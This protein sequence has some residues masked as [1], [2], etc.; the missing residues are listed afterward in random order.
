MRAHMHRRRRPWRRAA[1][2]LTALVAGGS[3][4]TAVTAATGAAG[5]PAACHDN[6]QITD[7]SGDGHHATTDVLAAWFS[8]AGSRLQ[9]VVQVRAGTW[10]AEHEDPEIPGSGFAV[11][12]TVAGQTRFVR[13]TAPGPDHPG[14]PVTYDH[15]TYTRAGGF[16]SAGATTGST[17]TAT[18]GTVTIDVPAATGAT[19]GVTLAN[20]FVLTYDGI[21]S[22]VPDWVDHA[23]GGTSPDD[24][25]RGADYVVGSCA[26]AT[27]TTGTGTTTP[28]GTIPGDAPPQPTS[29]VQ[30]TARSRVVGGGTITVS[31]RV[32]PAR[33]GV[34]VT[35]TR[36]A[37]R[38]ASTKA[39]TKAD[40]TFSVKVP[41]QETTELRAVAEGIG[42]QTRTVTAFTTVKVK[43]VR[44]RDGSAV[45]TGTV[46]PKLP[47]RVLWLRGDAISPSARTTTRAGAFRL[48]LPHPRHGRYQAVVIPTGDRAE[49]ATSNTGVIR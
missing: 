49:R 10:V 41:I 39:T 11:L 37:H 19:A 48:R 16:A 13:A 14:S 28:T 2:G 15:G 26:S 30:L 18:S 44:K 25:S 23:P 17:V 38:T 9:A 24:P 21:T 33:A 12:F 31:G 32:L 43:V 8:E 40:G 5:P 4:G 6:P 36:R 29:A 47:G 35:L 45:V 27:P 7:A 20:P 46:R 3:L 34:P 22:G 1:V 42:S